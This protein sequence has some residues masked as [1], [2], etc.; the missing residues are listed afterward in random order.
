[1]IILQVSDVGVFTSTTF[2]RTALNPCRRKQNF[3]PLLKALK[4]QDQSVFVSGK[5]L[6]DHLSANSKI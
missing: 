4:T 6:A 1:M 5:C 3:D 2:D